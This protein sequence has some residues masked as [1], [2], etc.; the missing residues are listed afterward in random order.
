MMGTHVPTAVG[1][2]AK[3]TNRLANHPST[4]RQPS[5]TPNTH[6]VVVLLQ[7]QSYASVTS[8]PASKTTS[9]PRPKASIDSNGYTYC[10]HSK[11]TRETCF[12]LHGY[13]DWWKGLKARKVANGSG[14]VA[15]V[16]TNPPCLVPQVVSTNTLAHADKPHTLSDSGNY[17]Y[18]FLTSYMS[19]S[20]KWIIDSGATDHMTFDPND[21]MSTTSPR[22]TNIANANNVTYPLTGAG[23][24]AL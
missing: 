8:S 21:F 16:T 13:L 23:T 5:Q 4:T 2:A 17:D 14:R 11:H 22:R 10:G 15:L 3:S 18:I 1:L 24:V 9:P 6:D 20:T 19:E 12:K 7:I